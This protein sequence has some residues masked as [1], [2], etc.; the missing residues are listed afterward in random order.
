MRILST[1]VKADIEYIRT[2]ERSNVLICAMHLFQS[3]VFK[4][5][6]KISIF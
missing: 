2:F 3:S 1:G 5:T 6:F 4:S